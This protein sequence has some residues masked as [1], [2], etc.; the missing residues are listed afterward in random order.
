MSPFRKECGAIE[1]NTELNGILWF[2]AEQLASQYFPNEDIGKAIGKP[3]DPPIIMVATS[4][5]QAGCLIPF[6]VF[7]ASYISPTWSIWEHIYGACSPWQIPSIIFPY[8]I[9]GAVLFAIDTKGTMLENTGDLWKQ[10]QHLHNIVSA[11]ESLNLS[12]FIVC[13]RHQESENSI[14]TLVGELYNLPRV[15]IGDYYTNSLSLFVVDLSAFIE[16]IHF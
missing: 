3:Y 14:T 10:R 16:S 11:I 12:L 1:M 13:L 7:K 4:D 9:R 8:P 5:T 15:T 6:K 2:G